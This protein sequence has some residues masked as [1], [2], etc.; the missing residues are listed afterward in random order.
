MPNEQLVNYFLNYLK[1]GYKEDS[2]KKA[3][4]KQGWPKEEVEEALKRAKSKISKTK[5]KPGKPEEERERSEIKE[6]KQSLEKPE[7]LKSE[8][9]GEPSSE[10]PEDEKPEDEK[11]EKELKESPEEVKKK[12]DIKNKTK[13]LKGIE[14]RELGGDILDNYEVEIDKAKVNIEIKKQGSTIFYDLNVPKIGI[15]T[16]SLLNEMRNELVSATTISMK[17]IAD[18]SAFNS[19]KRRFMKEASSL[20]KKNLPKISQETEDFLIG[21]LIQDMLGLGEI[22]FLVNDSALEEIV[23]PSSKE[24]IRVYH[25]KYGWVITNLIIPREDQ[26]INYSNIIARRVG[27]QITVLS[28]LLDAH[29]VSGDRVNSILYPI[30]TKGNTITIRKFARDPYT[31]VDLINNKTVSMDV[32]VILWLAIEYE[33]NILIS[34]GTASGKT[35]VLNAC[36]PFIPPNHRIISVE[37]TRELMLPDFLYWT[38]LVTRIPNPEGKGEVSM[39]HLLV[40]SLRMR[41][42]RI[43]LGEMRRQEEATVLFEAMHTGHSVYATLHADSAAETINRL[44]HPPLNVPPNLLKAVDLNIVMF[45]DRRKGIRR[46]LQIAEFEAEQESAK[47]NI[48]YRWIPE[49][50]TII[51]HAE[52]SKFFE[53]IERNTGLSE[54]ELDEKLEEKKKILSWLIKHKIR[55]LN[56]F[57]KVMNLY[58]TNKELLKD[59]MEKDDTKMILGGE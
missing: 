38:P 18:P 33:M 58:Y 43:I 20:I 9:K 2:L 55:D 57:G 24:P 44:T 29:L 21:K 15:A 16:A 54:K 40:N 25:K 28:P 45:R 30:C 11:P 35:V 17:E 59:C 39:L 13:Q 53:N 47:P 36:M 12:K 46:I 3:S 52:T 23:I 42:D 1:K 50:D 48:L 22:E 7:K 51:K 4:E 32:S 49:E 26:I 5:I 56:D 19:I 34:G 37:D 27:R 6:K 31:I 10:K 8:K 41:P 14:T